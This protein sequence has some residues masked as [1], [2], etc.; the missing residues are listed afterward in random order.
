MLTIIAI[1]ANNYLIYPYISIFTEK[2][3][4]LDLSSHLYT[5]MTVGV[6]KYIVGRSGEKIMKTWKEEK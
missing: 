1:V 5:L 3:T 2:A 6:G 4:V